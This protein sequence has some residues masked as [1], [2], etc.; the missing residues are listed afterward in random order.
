VGLIDY[1]TIEATKLWRSDGS[2][3]V[4]SPNEYDLVREYVPADWRW[5]CV[6]FDTSGIQIYPNYIRNGHKT[7]EASEYSMSS[8]DHPTQKKIFLQIDITTGAIK[9]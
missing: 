7:K 2:F 1:A 4:T 9:L 6:M 3:L 5:F 8:N